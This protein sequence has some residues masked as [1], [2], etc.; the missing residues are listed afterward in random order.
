MV[1]IRESVPG[2]LRELE[3]T[4]PF[5]NPESGE[6]LFLEMLKSVVPVLP[7]GPSP[8]A[9]E[10]VRHEVSFNQIT[11]TGVNT[12]IELLATRVPLGFV[13]RIWAINCIQDAGIDVA[14]E[15]L[16][17]YLNATNA[18]NFAQAR[19]NV[20]TGQDTNLI[21]SESQPTLAPWAFNGKPLDI[22]PGGRLEVRSRVAMAVGDNVQIGIFKTVLN[23]PIQSEPFNNITD[24][25]ITES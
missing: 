25:T 24:L 19:H 16:V 12:A 11:L 10:V 3:E 14:F 4:L 8:L 23:G 5:I 9:A 18:F 22:Y 15:V 1:A 6:P 13:H 20:I 21:G 17:E 2:F 7:I